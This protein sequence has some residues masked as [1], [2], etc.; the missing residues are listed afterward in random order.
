MINGPGPVANGAIEGVTL[1]V[2]G[3]NPDDSNGLT[4]P[5][6]TGNLDSS[7]TLVIGS[8]GPALCLGS[9][10]GIFLSARREA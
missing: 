3:P 6:F 8:D 9:Q 10:S 5:T 7:D 2:S 4:E 1:D